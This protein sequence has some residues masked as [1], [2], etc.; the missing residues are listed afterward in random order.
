[1]RV[2]I[3][4]KSESQR[5]LIQEALTNCASGCQIIS[6]CDLSK[7]P[8][9]VSQYRPE[10]AIVDL[11]TGVDEALNSISEAQ[12]AYP[13]RTIAIGPSSDAKLILR[14][15]NHGVDRYVDTANLNEELPASLRRVDAQ[16]RVER[17]HGKVIGVVGC[18]GGCGATTLVVNVGASLA[19]KGGA[20]H[21]IDLDLEKG[22]LA[23][24]LG[25]QG[26]HSIA[27]FCQSLSRMDEALLD[28][29]L[30]SCS[31]DLVLMSSPAD[32]RKIESVTPRGVRKA[33][34]MVR[35]R[36]PYVLIDI[37]NS[38]RSEQ[39]QA[40]FAA[41]EIL[42]VLRAEYT[43]VRQAS[44]VLAYLADLGIADDR[45]KLVVNRFVSR[46]GLRIS[47]IEN[48]LQRTI[49]MQIPENSK[50]MSAAVNRGTPLVIDRP[51]SPVS[52]S[53][54]ELAS[55]VNGVA[56]LGEHIKKVN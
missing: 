26:T 18:S 51:R 42:V 17:K 11:T 31:Q 34:N 10:V 1:M 33:I 27:E 53:L 16:P 48:S 6:S 28:K 50:H 21:L 30:T 40:L 39:A 25:V 23:A 41:D 32:Y 9:Q 24:M 47:D 3:A 5:T 29:C 43:S 7:F 36:G 54:F 12:E 45:V 38:F 14:T 20:T 2:L 52:S 35:S 56:K 55:S 15:L 22:D 8:E 46:A 4:G 19:K 44:R 13:A 49:H 37:A